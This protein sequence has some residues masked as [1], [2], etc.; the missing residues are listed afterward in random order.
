MVLLGLCSSSWITCG[1]ILNVE[2]E[3]CADGG[4]EPVLESQKFCRVVWKRE[5]DRLEGEQQNKL[6][7]GT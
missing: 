6:P 1:H 7:G 3:Q 2:A 4:V 5:G